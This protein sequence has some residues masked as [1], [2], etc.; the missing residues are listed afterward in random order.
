MIFQSCFSHPF[1]Q[2]FE[3]FLQ[4]FLSLFGCLAVEISRKKYVI[5]WN[6]INQTILEQFHEFFIW[7]GIHTC[8]HQFQHPLWQHFGI[9]CLQ[10]LAEHL[11][12]IHQQLQSN[13]TL[14]N[15]FSKVVQRKAILWPG[16][17]NVMFQFH[18][19]KIIFIDQ[20]IK[21][22]LPLFHWHQQHKRFDLVFPSYVQR[23]L[24]EKSDHRHWKF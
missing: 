18:K 21:Y 4:S 19:K 22:T 8:H 6:N 17:I 15:L 10:I 24:E 9:F 7:I 23:N 5:N 14:R 3:S 12:H 2:G 11:W 16:K 20:K 13:T 1:C